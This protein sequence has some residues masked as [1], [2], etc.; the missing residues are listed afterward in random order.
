MNFTNGKSH[1][2][3]NNQLTTGLVLSGGGSRAAYQVGALRALE[4]T[5]NGF[6]TP[7]SVIIGS[8]IGGVNGV[9]FA[10]CLRE[11]FSSAVA[12]LEALW[13]ERTIR[14]SFAGSISKTL[15]RSIRAAFFQYLSPGPKA[16]NLAIFDPTPL[17]QRI[18]E[19]LFDHGGASVENH[20]AN[21]EAIGVMATCEGEQRKGLLLVNAI[22]EIDARYMD[23]AGFEIH[24]VNHLSSSHAFASAALPFVLPPVELA[25]K[26]GNVSLVDG[27]IYD[28]TPVD[29]A[30][31][32]GAQ[33]ITIIDTSGKKW[34]CDH[35]G[36]PHDRHETWEPHRREGSY[37]LRPKKSLEIVNSIPFGPVLHH[38]IGNS[39]RNAIRA[40][41]PTWPIF[42]LLKRQMGEAL[43]YEVMSYAVIYPPYI[44]A[45]IE[46][47][48]SETI[49][50]FDENISADVL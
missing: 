8:S 1:S 49:A 36:H 47:G 42:K 16:T 29:P 7:Y 34:W 35:F 30:V 17:R 43:A 14:N 37:C 21:L 10:A 3:Q 20:P 48:Y 6:K 5:S 11:G 25:I 23:G 39:T 19:V 26:N 31:R 46:L 2:D 41:G 15:L 40:F 18:D 22:K 13:L 44:E 45:L 24:Y 27:G 32:F 4:Q 28:N 33:D 9:I 50:L 38:V 12:T